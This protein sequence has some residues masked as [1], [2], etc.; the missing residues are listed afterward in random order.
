MRRHAGDA[1]SPIGA[2][3]LCRAAGASRQRVDHT[4]AVKSIEDTLHRDRSDQETEDLLDDEHAP[5]VEDLS[6]SIRPLENERV[7]HEDGA[8]DRDFDRQDP[9]AAGLGRDRDQADDPDWV[10]QIGTASGTIASRIGSVVSAS[11]PA[12]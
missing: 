4:D 7:E 12:E 9:K 5:L 1:K 6:G 11:Q 3:L 2:L 10:E 8:Q